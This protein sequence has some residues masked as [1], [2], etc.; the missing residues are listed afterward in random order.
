MLLKKKSCCILSGKYCFI[1]LENQVASKE[2]Q[3]LGLW[4]NTLTPLQ[5]RALIGM[6]SKEAK[7]ETS[8]ALTLNDRGTPDFTIWKAYVISS[9]VIV[10]VFFLSR[11]KLASLEATLVTKLCRV[12]ESQSHRLTGVKCRATSVAKKVNTD[13]N[14]KTNKIVNGSPCCSWVTPIFP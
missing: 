10:I 9:R 4:L 6:M 8:M 1:L 7:I 13:I 2:I 14:T 12:S 5:S 3:A 11:H